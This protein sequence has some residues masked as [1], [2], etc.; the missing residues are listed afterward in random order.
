MCESDKEE[1]ERASTAAL[2]LGLSIREEQ[3]R[4]IRILLSS[5]EVVAL[6]LV[7]AGATV[8]ELKDFGGVIGAMTNCI[9]GEGQLLQQK[10]R[11]GVL[12]AK[13]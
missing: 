5:T 9:R 12:A 7:G 3:R 8:V 2:T 4:P 10:Q 1:E 13:K 6:L 11:S